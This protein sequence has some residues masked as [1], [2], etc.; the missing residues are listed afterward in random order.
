MKEQKGITL[1]ALIITIIIMLILVGVGVTFA[2]NGSLFDTAQNAVTKT[3]SALD[4]EDKL[5]RSTVN[6]D[7]QTPN[8]DIANYATD[9]GDWAARY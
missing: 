6:I 3:Q 5:D 1:I 4:Q 2:L 8:R 7:G 9:D